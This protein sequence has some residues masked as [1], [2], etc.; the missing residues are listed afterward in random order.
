MSRP[1]QDLFLHVRS[2]PNPNEHPTLWEHRLKQ[3]RP[4]S[5]NP[6]DHSGPRAQYEDT[7]TKRPSLAGNRSE[8]ENIQPG[9]A[10]QESS[11]EDVLTSNKN[12]DIV[13]G[14]QAPEWL[15][16]FY[17]LAWTATFASLTSNNKFKA[18]W[19]SVTYVVF[20]TIAW[21][22]WTSQVFYSIDFY[23]DD[24]F[25][26]L[27]VFL[28][29]I[30]FGA[31]AAVTRGIDVSDYIL[32][33][34]DSAAWEP[35]DIESMTPEAYS[36]DKVTMISFEA[37]ALVLAFSRLLLLVQH[38]RVVIYAKL[39]TRSKSFPWKLILVPISLAIST[40]LFF[41]AFSI[42]RG[43]GTEINGAKAK[44]YLWAV[45]IFVEIVA[46]IIWLQW[47]VRDGLSLKSHGSIV[48][49]FCGITTII[50]GE[51]I[52]AIA[53][54]FYALEKAPGFG[55]PTA[56][57][58]VSCAFIVFFLV[59]LYF[60]GAAPLQAVRRRAAWAMVHLPWLLSTILLLE[61]VKNQLL[62]SGFLNSVGHMLG[63]TQD[64]LLADVDET[65]FSSTFGYLLLQVG[66]SLDDQYK[67][68][69]DLE[70]QYLSWFNLTALDDDSSGVVLEMWY[71]RLKMTNIV[72]LYVTFMDNDTITDGIHETIFQYQNDFNTTYQDVIG[73]E[74]TILIETTWQLIKSTVTNARY[75][76]ALS[77]FTFIS[78][79]VMNLIQSWPRD[80]FQWASIIS[81]F[82]M[83][84]AMSIL[85]LLNIGKYQVYF[86]PSY[87]ERA[88]IFNWIDANWVLPTIALAYGL[89]FIID[90]ILVY[91]A[92]WFTRKSRTGMAETEKME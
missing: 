9:K 35:T 67:K 91:V 69:S 82:V 54:T 65:T 13:W 15:N 78:L 59:Y 56:G 10:V 68:Y 45:G 55:G 72:N 14:E 19:D 12:Q 57:G 84:I 25:H 36:A 50:I 49:R 58:I 32:H 18:P 31:L 86:A 42:T 66:I 7:N 73:I 29:L 77:G 92:V 43:H 6:F 40:A 28:Q 79:A 89:Q 1:R 51:G 81:R 47:D 4:L 20:F 64:I 21:W 38:I 41:A 11:Q 48:N 30:I 53:G 39:T 44:F 70:D 33:S 16:L 46:H 61:G 71:A 80:R 24:W 88:G 2:E 17:D 63:A 62:L 76:M 3:R 75:I 26:L 83:G 90:T 27:V 87:P 37:I 34:P 74:E 60:Q 8:S 22:I 5:L 52:N 23:T 85:L